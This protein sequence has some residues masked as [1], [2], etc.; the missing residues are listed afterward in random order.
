MSLDPRDRALQSICPCLIVP[1][2]GP[3]PA[4]APGQRV[5]LAANGT[6]LEVRRS[7]LHCVL[8]LAALPKAPP[9]PFGEVRERVDLS[10]G[11]IPI[12]LLEQFIEAGRTRLPNEIAGALIF[13]AT[14]AQRL[15]LVM[16]ETISE[17]PDQ[18]HYRMPDLGPG[19]EIAVD[20]HTHG[21]YSAGWSSTDDRDD[22]GIKVCGVFGD[23]HRDR[24]SAAFRLAVN[25]AFRAL[26]H[27]W[28]RPT[29]DGRSE[30]DPTRYWPTLV[31]MGFVEA[32]DPWN[33]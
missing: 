14:A 28:Q 10:F 23:L 9:L 24:P 27:P 4:M 20:L 26:P 25:G 7:W 19:D 16:H 5:L 21:R 8:Q 32:D 12:A 31:S 13:N 18:V 3:L 6:F 2:F 29:R 22:Q 15:R 11:V 1:R 30:V 33:I 17:R